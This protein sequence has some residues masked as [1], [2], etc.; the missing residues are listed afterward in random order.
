MK[1]FTLFITFLMFA[2]ITYANDKENKVKGVILSRIS[3]FVT[4]ESG[5]RQ[6]TI[7]VYDDKSMSSSL[8]KLYKDK[9]HNG[10]PIKIVNISENESIPRCDIFYVDDPSSKLIRELKKT[11]SQYTLLVSDSV[12]DLDDGFM[13][14]LYI[15]SN[16]INI[17]INQQALVDANL[18]VN[19]RLLKV[20]TKIVNPVKN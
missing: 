12:E 13:L 5:K 15:K 9:E 1:F 2:T 18:K 19:Y 16:K 4:Y 11:S 20:A 8:E 6:F 17:A 14:A 7:C 3:Q 10:V